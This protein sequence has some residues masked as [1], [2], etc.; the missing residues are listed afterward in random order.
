[1]RYR[2]LPQIYYTL[3]AI[4]ANLF[5]RYRPLPQIC[6]CATGHCRK[7]VYALEATAANCYALQAI[8][9]NLFMLYRP[10]PKICL[11]ATGH[12]RK[13]GYALRTTVADLNICYG[14]LCR[15]KKQSKN[16]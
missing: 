9:A 8:A 3:Q 14:P 4:S 1:M 13:F 16:L 10:L 5:V 11:N 12:C 2:P 6:L 7:F 15:K